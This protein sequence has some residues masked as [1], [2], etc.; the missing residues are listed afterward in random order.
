MSEDAI[1]I[2]LCCITVFAMNVFPLPLPPSFLAMAMFY[3]ASDVPL[4]PLVLF[5]T[6]SAACARAVFATGVGRFTDRIP[7]KQRRNAEA[8]ARYARKKVKRPAV[9]VGAYSFTGLTSNP[10]FVAVGLGALPFFSSVAAY[11]VARSVLNT[12]MV[13]LIAYVFD[14][15]DTGDDITFLSIVIALGLFAGAYL[16]FLNLPWARWLGMDDEDSAEPGPAG[17]AA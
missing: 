15:F 5:S 12:I 8:F 6:F 10:L 11:F 2:L 7:E 1:V 16:V 4:V 17:E 9:F 14:Y 3:M 13:Y